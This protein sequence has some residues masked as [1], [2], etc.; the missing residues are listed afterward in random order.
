M[1]HIIDIRKRIGTAMAEE[2]WNVLW[3]VFYVVSWRCGLPVALFVLARI[4]IVIHSDRSISY[5]C[6][7]FQK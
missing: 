7:F 4:V 2:K 1:I 5:H 3:Y 6:K